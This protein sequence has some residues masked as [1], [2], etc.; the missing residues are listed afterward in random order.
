[1]S[2]EESQSTIFKNMRV[3]QL[4]DYL[5]NRGVS[6]HGYLKPALIEIAVAVNKM[7]L[8]LNPNLKEKKS[9]EEEKSFLR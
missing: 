5:Q 4:K 7:I 9:L 2:F 6:V 3:S 1:M 8:P